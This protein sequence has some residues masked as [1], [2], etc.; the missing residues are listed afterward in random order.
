MDRLNNTLDAI[1][2]GV[3]FCLIYWGVGFFCKST[4][5]FEIRN[6]KGYTICLV[7]GY[8]VPRVIIN[9]ASS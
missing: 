3:I 1:F 6:S 4:F 7:L 9:L 8:V 2:L 5:G